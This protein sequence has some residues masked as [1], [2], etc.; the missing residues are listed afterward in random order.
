MRILLVED[1]FKMASFI[2]KGLEAERYA[3]DLV[4]DGP[5]GMERALWQDYDLLILDLMLPGLS[6]SDILKTVRDQKPTI[7][8]LILTARDGLPDKIKHFERGCDDYLT[9]PFAFAELVMRVKALLRRGAVRRSNDLQVADL[10]LDRNSRR[11]L[12]AGKPID[13]TAKE[14]ALLEYLMLNAGQVCSRAILIEHVWD[15]SFDTFTNIVDVYIRYLRNKIDRHF[16][17][18]LIHT[19]RG[20]GYVLNSGEAP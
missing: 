6:G 4:S 1:E 2:K 19:V 15:Q 16:E 20:V 3:V 12:R 17:P 11:V 8:I 13:M 9:K 5:S 10:V 7:P 18:K 14:F